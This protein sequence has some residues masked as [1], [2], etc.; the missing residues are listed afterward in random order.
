MP[1]RRRPGSGSRPL[2]CGRGRRL[3]PGIDL[4]GEGGRS[5]GVG[6]VEAGQALP[7]GGIAGIGLDRPGIQ[8]A[9]LVRAAGG[10]G[11]P[12][13]PGPV[14]RGAER[15]LAPEAVAGRPP[16]PARPRPCGAGARPRDRAGPPGGPARRGAPGP[17]VAAGST[18]SQR[19]SAA[20]SAS[21]S[22]RCCASHARSSR[23]SS[24]PSP[25]GPSCR[26]ASI[27]S[28]GRPEPR[29]H[30]SQALQTGASGQASRQR[31]SQTDASSQR[32]PSIASRALPSQTRSSSGAS[33][34]AFS[35]APFRPS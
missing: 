32:P 12:G 19:S 18:R 14:G 9:G 7:G 20:D 4:R 28:A 24:G 17:C 1:A 25:A 11:Q 2:G 26:A 8:G 3:G 15:L 22:P 29:A 21:V 33:W 31:V 34:P 16:S 13:Q 23:R 27:A 5:P 10:L 30:S 35:R 6:A